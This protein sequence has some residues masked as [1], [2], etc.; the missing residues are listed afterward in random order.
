MLHQW[1]RNKSCKK[2]ISMNIKEILR[3]QVLSVYSKKYP[4]SKIDS[5][6][7]YPSFLFLNAMPFLIIYILIWAV[8]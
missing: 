1:E 5:V 3:N 4:V 6:K 7:K 8:E 2:R